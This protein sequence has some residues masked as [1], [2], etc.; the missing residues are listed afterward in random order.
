MRYW[1]AGFGKLKDVVGLLVTLGVPEK[2][3]SKSS[4]PG[5]EVGNPEQTILTIEAEEQEIEN[6]GEGV[7]EAEM[8]DELVV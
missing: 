4:G 5:P 2:R 6:I 1:E 7:G 8:A 3:L